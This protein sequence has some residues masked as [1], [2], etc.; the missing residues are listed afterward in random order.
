MR[1]CRGYHDDTVSSNNTSR[2]LLTGEGPG[3]AA[4][5]AM[6]WGAVL[7]G[8]H[9][10]YQFW[11]YLDPFPVLREGA[12]RREIAPSNQVLL[13]LEVVFAHRCVC[14]TKYLLSRIAVSPFDTP[15]AAVLDLV[16]VTLVNQ[17]RIVSE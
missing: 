3:I 17:A 8:V 16:E 6:E 2:I 14:T 13:V 15:L 5:K 9:R 10:Q 12:R 1:G 4:P 11:G 7:T